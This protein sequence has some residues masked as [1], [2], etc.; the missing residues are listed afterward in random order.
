MVIM[1]GAKNLKINF[2]V[3]PELKNVLK[4]YVNTNIL[5]HMGVKNVY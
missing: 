1:N 4:S 5:C 2:Q 3:I